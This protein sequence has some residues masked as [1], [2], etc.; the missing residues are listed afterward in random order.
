[1]SH[2]KSEV[3][4]YSPIFASTSPRV[5][6]GKVKSHSIDQPTCESSALPVPRPRK[7]IASTSSVKTMA[8]GRST[9]S[10]GAASTQMGLPN[11][12]G[13]LSVLPGAYACSAARTALNVN[14]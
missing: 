8:N 6:T 14:V 10:A 13:L 1:V 3:S 12:G 4:P 11:S 2:A 9:A 7:K 5:G